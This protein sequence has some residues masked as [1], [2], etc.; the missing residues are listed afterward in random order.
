[1][2]LRPCLMSLMKNDSTYRPD[3]AYIHVWCIIPGRHPGRTARGKHVQ[4]VALRW[5]R[6]AIS[7]AVLSWNRPGGRPLLQ[8]QPSSIEAAS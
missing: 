7:A 1:M 8:R 3:G 5:P 4:F 6:A 2:I